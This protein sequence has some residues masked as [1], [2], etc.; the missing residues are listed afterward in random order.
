MRITQLLSIPA[1]C[2]LAF[3]LLA[4]CQSSTQR[5]C[6]Y[7]PLH[8]TSVPD[9]MVLYNKIANTCRSVGGAGC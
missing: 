8:H 5:R 9:K 3:T 6:L 4:Y 2:C 1:A 7:F